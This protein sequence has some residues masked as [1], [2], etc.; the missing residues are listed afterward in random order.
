MGKGWYEWSFV[1]P[2]SV[3]WHLGRPVD[4]ALCFLCSAMQFGYDSYELYAGVVSIGMLFF[5]PRILHLQL[6]SAMQ[7]DA[8][9]LSL[10]QAAFTEVSFANK[11]EQVMV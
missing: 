2:P 6:G 4:V 5:F 7:D 8:E 10:H 9:C 1:G 11:S 3:D